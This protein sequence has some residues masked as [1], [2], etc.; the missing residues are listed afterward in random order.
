MPQCKIGLNDKLGDTSNQK[1]FKSIDIDD[2]QFHQCVQ[3]QKFD[4]D[5][6]ISFIPP[7]IYLFNKKMVNLN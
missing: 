4:N 2:V 1:K 5:K 3:L 6:S 7:G